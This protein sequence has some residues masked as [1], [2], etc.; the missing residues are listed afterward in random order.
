M[1]PASK[2]H[3]ANEI[4]RFQNI[5]TKLRATI[6]KYA[7]IEFLKRLFCDPGLLWVSALVLFIAEIIVNILVI[8]RVPCNYHNS[9]IIHISIDQS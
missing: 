6:R 4:G 9:I 8:R 2:R 3:K 1:A 7:N 5:Q